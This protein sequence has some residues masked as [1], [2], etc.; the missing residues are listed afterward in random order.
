MLQNY[1]IPQWGSSAPSLKSQIRPKIHFG[2]S[3][4]NV[5]NLLLKKS[6]LVT[7]TFRKFQIN[8]KIIDI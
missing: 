2:G 6:C 1:T 3:L 8:F 4:V 7:N 5:Y